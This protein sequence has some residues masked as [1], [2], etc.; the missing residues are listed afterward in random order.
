[1]RVADRGTR[2]LQ[3]LHGLTQTSGVGVARVRG[4]SY[5]MASWGTHREGIDEHAERPKS[6][7]D[8]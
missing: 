7:E 5:V 8:A 6:G 1:M 3:A 2:V 4:V